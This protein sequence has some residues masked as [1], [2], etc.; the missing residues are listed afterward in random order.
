MS[1]AKPRGSALREACLREALAIIG[2]NGVEALSLREVARRLGV[3]H[4]APYKHFAS[5]DHILADI[6]ARAFEDFA[7]HLDERPA[8]GDAAEDGA[9]MGRAY[10]AYARAHPLQYRLMF[11]G[12]VPD[13]SQHPAMMARAQHAFGLL[14][15][16]L[17]GRRPDADDASVDLDALFV[18]A[19]VHGIATILQSPSIATLQLPATTLAAAETHVLSRIKDAFKGSHHDPA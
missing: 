1:A 18:W 7:A 4:Q 12:P 6:I 5:R 2:E 8:G 13:P 11:G 10:L 14:R 15:A 19:S 16:S 17:A 9:N 3:S